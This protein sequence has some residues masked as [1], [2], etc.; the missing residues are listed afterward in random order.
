MV[1]DVVDKIVV[2]AERFTVGDV[3][4]SILPLSKQ[5]CSRGSQIVRSVV[6]HGEEEEEGE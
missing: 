6:Y 1:L 3:I 4:V 2:S 5:G